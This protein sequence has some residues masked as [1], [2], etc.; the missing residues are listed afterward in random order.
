MLRA[1]RDG[2]TTILE[3]PIIRRAGRGT[4]AMYLLVRGMVLNP[5]PVQAVEC[6][7]LGLGTSFRGAGF[8]VRARISNIAPW[9]R[10]HIDMIDA[11]TVLWNFDRF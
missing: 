5:D 1:R 6:R 8:D 10:C 7:T 11:T 9:P 4:V 2:R 3:G